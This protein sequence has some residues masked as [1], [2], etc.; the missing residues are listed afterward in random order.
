MPKQREKERAPSPK[1]GEGKG[2][3]KILTAKMTMR[4]PKL[5]QR[6]KPTRR[7]FK[8]L[9]KESAG[10]GSETKSKRAMAGSRGTMAGAPV[11]G[12]KNTAE[13]QNALF[14]AVRCLFE[15]RRGCLSRRARR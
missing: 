2:F 10:V 1:W 13:M 8:K 3:K 6:Q 9:K 12:N 5:R 11:L 14:L 4:L 7:R 15:I